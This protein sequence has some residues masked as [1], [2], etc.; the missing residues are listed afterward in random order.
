MSLNVLV[1]FNIHFFEY[2]FNMWL[3]AKTRDD[4]EDLFS[5]LFINNL[6]HVSAFCGKICVTFVLILQIVNKLV[7]G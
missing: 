2:V 1:A 4:L 6:Y 5:T 3:C 7:N